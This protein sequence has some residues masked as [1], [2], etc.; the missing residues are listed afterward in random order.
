MGNAENSRVFGFDICVTRKT[1]CR[2]SSSRFSSA[3]VKLV[4]AQISPTETEDA[5]RS[6]YC[7][8]LSA[9]NSLRAPSRNQ[10][11]CGTPGRCIICK[12]IAVETR[13]K[14]NEIVGEYLTETAVETLL[15]G[16]NCAGNDRFDVI[17]RDAT[18]SQGVQ[19]KRDVFYSRDGKE[20]AQQP[21]S[22]RW[23][24]RLAS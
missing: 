19:N 24:S 9:S 3:I 1:T 11:L 18:P 2:P 8:L 20:R 12:M 4:P 23:K 22:R 13:A 21:P 5:R 15:H 7:G 17:G 6:T 10:T 14:Q 16:C